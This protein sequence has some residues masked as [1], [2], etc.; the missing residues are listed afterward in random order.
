[1][2][3]KLQS[4]AAVATTKAVNGGS[5]RPCP[6]ESAETLIFATT[7]LAKL[8]RAGSV[9]RHPRDA[10]SRMGSAI[11]IRRHTAEMNMDKVESVTVTQSILGRMLDYGTIHVRGTGVGIE[12]LRD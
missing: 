1:M 11:F 10:P 7:K 2:I 4:I 6:F 12:H 8:G 9:P 5:P 3:A